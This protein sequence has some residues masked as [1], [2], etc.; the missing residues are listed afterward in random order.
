MFR[1]KTDVLWELK[2]S[3]YST[4]RLR[5]DKILGGKAIEALRK[6]EMVGIHVLERICGILNR[7]PGELIEYVPDEEGI[8]EGEDIE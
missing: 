6:K 7:Q 1:Y 2:V 5:E 8:K 4:H 3:G